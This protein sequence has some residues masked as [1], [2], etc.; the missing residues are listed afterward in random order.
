MKKK[1]ISVLVVI[2]S[3]SMIGCGQATNVTDDSERIAKIKRELEELE[4]EN[5]VLRAELEAFIESSEP[6]SEP[7]SELESDINEEP[8][9]EGYRQ[10]LNKDMQGEEA[11]TGQVAETEQTTGENDWKSAYDTFLAA[12]NVG[13]VEIENADASREM[14]QDTI[15]LQKGT[16]ANYYSLVDI[17]LDG[18]PEL[19]WEEVS[20]IEV[21][22]FLSCEDGV[23]R[24][25]D[26]AGRRA[27]GW[28]LA[29]QVKDTPYYITEHD[30]G[31]SYEWCLCTIRDGYRH[32]LLSVI[33]SSEFDIDEPTQYPLTCYNAD[34]NE[35]TEDEFQNC[36]LELTGY[37][38]GNLATD[39]EYNGEEPYLVNLTDAGTMRSFP[40]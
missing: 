2:M 17:N 9:K 11:V 38:I 14:I 34:G 33:D 1:L 15:P 31:V 35:I 32:A 7:S 3:V 13:T 27:L 5:E 21:F 36:F 40:E 8:R 6:S 28:E 37:S 4:E 24:E 10:Y 26:V 23:V 12:L 19:I 29:W 39:P 25:F 22:H 18:I 16:D 30:T 20:A